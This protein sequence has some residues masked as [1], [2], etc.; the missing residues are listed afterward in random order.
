MSTVEVAFNPFDPSFLV[1]PY[2]HWQA[3]REASPVHHTPLDFWVLTRYDDVLQF[4]R[5]PALS[6]EDRNARPGPLAEITR[7]ALGGEPV[8]DGAH[9]MLSRDAPDHTRL[10]KLVSKA[11]TPKVIAGLR[12]R[13]QQLVDEALDGVE[14]RG[15]MELIGDLAFPLPFTI[16]SEMLGMPDADSSQLREWSGT[17]VRSL[18]PIVDPDLIRAIADAGEHMNRFTAEAIAWKRRQPADD[19]LSALIAAE[20]DGDVLS[21]EELIDQI[22][23]LY[24]AGHETTVNL[25]GNGTLALLNHRSE[26]ERLQADPALDG[27]AIEELL[28]YDPPVQMTRRITLR[29]VELRGQVIDAASFVVCV[30]ASA[31]RDPSKWGEDAAVLNLARDDA[32]NHLAFGG[33][34]HYCLG[35]ALARLEGQIAIGTLVRRFERLELAG[36]PEWNGRINLRGLDRLPLALSS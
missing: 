24:V 17:I 8:D 20:D 13:I 32:H 12:P 16:I 28:R 21:D 5:D 4:V 34:I 19:L 26:L 29:D 25:I 15:E 9:A 10:R 14:P 33:G 3:L 2:P 36:E 31:N 35:A 27:N 1:D 7:Q 11:F 6:V 30:I 18:E 23:L 22:V